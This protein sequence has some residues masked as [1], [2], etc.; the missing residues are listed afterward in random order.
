[1]SVYRHVVDGHE[2]FTA[3]FH[4]LRDSPAARQTQAFLM[5]MVLEQGG[6]RR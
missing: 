3:V 1:M 6:E 2:H 4:L 5:R